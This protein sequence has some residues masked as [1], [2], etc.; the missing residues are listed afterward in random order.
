MARS[1]I[2]SVLFYAALTV[3]NYGKLTVVKKLMYFQLTTD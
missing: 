1:H 3:G 2:K